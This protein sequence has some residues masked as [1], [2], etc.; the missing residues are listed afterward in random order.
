M[1]NSHT[2]ESRQGARPTVVPCTREVLKPMAK[3]CVRIVYIGGYREYAGRPGR[4]EPM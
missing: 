1:M 2:P 4:L 3:P